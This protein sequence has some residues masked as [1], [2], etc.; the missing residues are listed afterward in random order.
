MQ[1]GKLGELQYHQTRV[2]VS[3]QTLAAAAAAA[4]ELAV[5]DRAHGSDRRR[6][7]PEQA[8]AWVAAE[9][10]L[11]PGCSR[12]SLE[13][14]VLVVEGDGERKAGVEHLRSKT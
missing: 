12:A 11:Q 7:D 8:P 10:G 5:A 9:G 2:D 6:E 3:V 13:M 14:A 1:D 4:A